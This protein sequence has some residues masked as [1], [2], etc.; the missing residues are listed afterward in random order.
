MIRRIADCRK[1]T[2]KQYGVS[3]VNIVYDET[4]GLSGTDKSQAVFSMPLSAFS[5]SH[6]AF[7]R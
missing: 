6:I 7:L 2:V 4:A 1:T 5:D 3:A